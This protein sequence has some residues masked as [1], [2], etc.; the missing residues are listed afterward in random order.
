SL[1]AAFSRTTCLWTMPPR[2]GS[3][4]LERIAQSACA[5]AARMRKKR[6]H[7]KRMSHMRF[8]WQTS[9]DRIPNAAGNYVTHRISAATP[10]NADRCAMDPK[11]DLLSGSAPLQHWVGLTIRPGSRWHDR[12]LLELRKLPPHLP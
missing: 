8:I 1:A 6:A 2:P 12:C 4:A 10:E 11:S 3:D 9:F 5:V 7:L